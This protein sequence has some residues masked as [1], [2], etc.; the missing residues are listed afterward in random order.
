MIS[1]KKTREVSNPAP[2][3]PMK[4][5][6]IERSTSSYDAMKKMMTEPHTHPVPK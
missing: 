3:M 2:Q 4:R 6:T 1:Q 5:I